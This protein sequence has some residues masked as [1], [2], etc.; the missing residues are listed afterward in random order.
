MRKK[1]QRLALSVAVA[2]MALSPLAQACTALLY[3]DKQG[4]SYVGRTLELPMELPYYLAYSPV[5][6]SFGSEADHHHPLTFTAKY[7]F[8]SIGLPDFSVKDLKV[9]D[10]INDQ[11]LAFS[12]L[13]FPATKGPIDSANKTQAVL[14]AIDLGAWSLA[15]F[16]TVAE[17]KKAL[18]TQPT[19]VTELLPF[20]VLDT[21][22]HYILHDATGASIVI[23]YA[24]GQ[25]NVYDNPIGVM[26]N[27]PEFPWHLK[28]LDNYTFLNNK[29][30]STSS[31]RG[32][33]FSQPDTGIATVALPASNTAV[34][35]FVRATYYSQYA[36]QAK[37]PT[38]AVTTLAHV[39]NNFDRPRGITMDS[40][41]DSGAANAVAPE[42]VGHPGYI[43]EYTTWTSLRDLEQK[44]YYVRTYK[45][46]MHYSK[47]DLSQLKGGK[48]SA[49]K[50][51][52]AAE[53][54]ELDITSQLNVGE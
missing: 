27:G 11:G 13:A 10:G 7:D 36:E 24:D 14:A 45:N 18:E 31:F 20:D 28:N 52:D 6:T 46:G 23:E 5:G 43:S 51:S 41:F 16:A 40:R 49:I 8:V 21:P 39:M 1:V 44:H 34:G 54:N 4:N 25:Q 42:V 2:S 22:F 35:R 29:D 50:L 32:Q 12:L 48:A 3:N 17:V 15:Q 53:A 33:H 47:I 19:Q 38:E 37:T 9:I 26:T 30:V